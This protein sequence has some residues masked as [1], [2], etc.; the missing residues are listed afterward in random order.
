MREKKNRHKSGLIRPGKTPSLDNSWEACQPPT[1]LEGKIFF[2]GARLG[3][4]PPSFSPLKTP[5]P[6]THLK[7]FLVC[8]CACMEHAHVSLPAR[9]QLPL[10]RMHGCHGH[11]RTAIMGARGQ[12]SRGTRTAVAGARGRLST[13]GRWLP[14]RAASRC[15][16][17][18]ACG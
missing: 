6:P 16:L 17:A 8:A 9:G 18:G 4:H 13:D 14:V 5:I 11:A 15:G 12:P 3:T 2:L 10:A 1:H 7:N